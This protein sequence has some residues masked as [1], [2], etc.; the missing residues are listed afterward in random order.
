M[1]LE[2]KVQQVPQELVRLRVEPVQQ[3][4]LVPLEL[5]VQQELQE[6]ELLLV[7]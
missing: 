6:L 5:K 2:L 3:E 7:V 4:L 1:P